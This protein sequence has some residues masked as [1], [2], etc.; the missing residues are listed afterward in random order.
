MAQDPTWY[1]PVCDRLL[2]KIQHWYQVYD[3]GVESASRKWITMNAR[4]VDRVTMYAHN[5][6]FKT[7][8]IDHLVRLLDALSPHPELTADFKLVRAA[9]QRGRLYPG[10]EYEVTLNFYKQDV[11]DILN[12]L[13]RAKTGQLKTVEQLAKEQAASGK[14]MFE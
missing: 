14:G 7:Q 4:I 12:V 5:L 1:V 13:I 10:G 11:V 6:K 2:Q 3:R 8:E 9:M